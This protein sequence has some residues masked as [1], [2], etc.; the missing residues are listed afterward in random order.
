MYWKLQ[1]KHPLPIRLHGVL[2]NYLVQGQLHLLQFMVQTVTTAL[3]GSSLTI[4]TS[5][6]PYEDPDNVHHE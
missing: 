6:L 2:F 1:N 5:V 3:W 4:A